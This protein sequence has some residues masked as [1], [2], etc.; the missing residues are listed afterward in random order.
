MLAVAV[1]AIRGIRG[2]RFD[3]FAVNA[4]NKSCRDL[5]VTIATRSSNVPMADRRLRVLCRQNFVTT[6][7]VGTHSGIFALQH[8]ASM[9]ALQILL[10]GMQDRYFMA[11]QKAVIR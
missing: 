5:L 10:D 3:G 1:R 8:C 4:G 7:A 6:V 2:A 9:H 11:R